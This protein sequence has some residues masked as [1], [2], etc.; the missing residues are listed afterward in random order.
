MNFIKI[1]QE[2][3]PIFEQ[4]RYSFNKNNNQPLR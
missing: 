2:K 3:Y 4:N 1:K